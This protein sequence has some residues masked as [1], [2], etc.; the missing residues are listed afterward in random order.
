MKIISKVS[1]NVF[2]IYWMIRLQNGTYRFLWDFSIK[3]NI[4]K[5]D[6]R[7]Q[8]TNKCVFIKAPY[9]PKNLRKS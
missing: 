6:N 2:K 3:Y 7:N 8:R 9:H 1:W 4:Y 5:T